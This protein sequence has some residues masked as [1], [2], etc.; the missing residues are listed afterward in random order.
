MAPTGPCSRCGPF[1]AGHTWLPKGRKGDLAFFLVL[2]H[3]L[4]RGRYCRTLRCED[5]VRMPA[6]AVLQKELVPKFSDL[7]RAAKSLL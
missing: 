4:Q 3:L 2:H 1:R 5:D 6:S 7:I